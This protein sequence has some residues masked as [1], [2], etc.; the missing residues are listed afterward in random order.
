MAMSGNELRLLCIYLSIAL[1]YLPCAVIRTEELGGPDGEEIICNFQN[2]GRF[3]IS[4]LV[5]GPLAALAYAK[6][7][8]WTEK[9][10]KEKCYKIR[11]NEET[12]SLVSALLSYFALFINCIVSNS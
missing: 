11:C 2:Q 5:L 9:D 4:G 8:S 10:A 12:M 7:A 3:L 6:F 1:R